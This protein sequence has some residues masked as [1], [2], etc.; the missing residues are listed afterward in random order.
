M[1][2]LRVISW[3]VLAVAFC[4]SFSF[5]THAADFNLRYSNFFPA[6]HKNA[7]LADQWCKEIE[8]RTNGRVKVSYFPG[9]TLTPPTQTYDSVVKGIADIGQTL[10]AYSAGRFL[11]TEVLAQP[12]GYT[13]GRP[14]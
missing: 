9:N 3:I 11:L 5:R 1:K 6:P 2:H 10:A 14:S 7:I 8:K 13:A 12:I 4:V